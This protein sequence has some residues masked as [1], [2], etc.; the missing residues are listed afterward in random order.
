VGLSLLMMG[1]VLGFRYLLATAGAGNFAILAALYVYIEIMAALV[2]IQFWTFA[3]D[4]FDARQAKRLFGLI[5]AGGVI[6]NIL[7]GIGLQAAATVIAPADLLFVVV[8]SLLG[9]AWAV[10][11]LERRGEGKEAAVVTS[12]PAVKQPASNLRQDLQAVW[13]TPLLVSI[14]SIMILMSL[15]TNIA[16]YQLDLSLQ[17]FFSSD[18]SGMLAFLGQFQ[19]VTGTLALAVQLFATN[20]LME[21]F[22]LVTS[23]LILPASIALGSGLIL[24]TGGVLLAAAWP[25]GSDV[26]FRYTVNDAALNTLFLPVQ[27]ALRRRA[28][29]I[30]DGI[31]KP[32]IVGLMGFAFLLFQGDGSG[33]QASTIVSWSVPVLLLTAGWLFLVQ[34]VR[35]QYRTALADS[36]RRRRLDLEAA[37]IDVSDETTIQVLVQ[38]LQDPDEFQVVHALNLMNHAPDVDWLP[39]IAPHVNHP[40]PAVRLIVLRLL[41]ESRRPEFAELIVSQFTAAEAQVRAA[42]IEAYCAL[43]EDTAVEAVVTFLE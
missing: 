4:I 37:E 3:A 40:S 9:C 41:Q 21:R 42:A 22:G 11:A 32:P 1:G 8:A 30:L 33:V 10:F 18:G 2:G 7:A 31:V 43:Q 26:V 12:S 6:S 28:K 24:V 36:L 13:R 34:R 38:S 15:V 27:P 29:A 17:R 23:L 19:I 39:Y 35:S 5:A 25:R 16:D 14:G 20:R